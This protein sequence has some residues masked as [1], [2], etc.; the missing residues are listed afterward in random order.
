MLTH[1]HQTDFSHVYQMIEEAQARAWKEV[2]KSLITLYW[3]I[4]QY[5]SAYSNPNRAAI[6]I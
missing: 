3:N 5:V 1:I 6:P 4:G 2:N